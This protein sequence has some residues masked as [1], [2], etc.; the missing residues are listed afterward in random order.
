MYV[1]VHNTYTREENVVHYE[2]RIIQLIHPTRNLG[3]QKN[4]EH[5]WY[6]PCNGSG[7]NGRKIN[8]SDACNHKE[9]SA[10]MTVCVDISGWKLERVGEFL[11]K[12]DTGVQRYFF[13]QVFVKKLT[14]L[15][16]RKN[17]YDM[18]YTVPFFNYFFV[19]LA[20]YSVG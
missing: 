17:K 20:G 15:L 16:H 1:P 18:C 7:S 8:F 6:Q 10:T 19:F 12:S 13:L 9:T 2:I 3:Q 11:L 4:L 5:S 14:P